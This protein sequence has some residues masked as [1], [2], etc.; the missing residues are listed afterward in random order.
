MAMVSGVVSGPSDRFGDAWCVAGAERA[1]R[2]PG[3]PWPGEPGL[4]LWDGNPELFEVS[5]AALGLEE[6]ALP[7]GSSL[8]QLVGVLAFAYGDYQVWPSQLHAVA[9]ELPRAV[10]ARADGERT[11]ASW[12]L[13]RLSSRELSAAELALRTDKAARYVVD[14]LGAPDV[15]AVQEIGSASDLDGLAAAVNDLAADVVYT[16]VLEPSS[17]DIEVGLLVRSSVAVAA[18]QSFG[19]AA[20]FELDGESWRTFDR[21]PLLLTGEVVDNGE[22]FP[23]SVLDVHLRSMNGIDEARDGPF[24]RAK[25]AAQARWLAA[26]LESRQQSQP[27]ERL[28]VVGDFNAFQF[29]DG[30]V[31]V[32]GTIVGAPDPA[33]AMVPAEDLVTRD[34]TVWTTRI[35]PEERYSF[36][37][38]GNA[39][40]FDHV[41][42]VAPMNDWVREVVYGRGNAD[43]P[44]VWQE[45]PASPLR[46]SDHDGVVLFLMTDRDGDG[47]GDDVDNCP[48]VVNPAQ[49]DADGD[50]VGDVCD[51]RTPRRGQRA[52]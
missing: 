39:Q 4:P 9:A 8:E 11:V 31:D 10:R 45:Q 22:P 46:S 27:E 24:V 23:L 19:E 16:S 30:W 37:F 41:L 29:T 44:V 48:D 38:E 2:E 42:T 25:R 21:P 51:G 33:G 32:L 40:A 12:N 6:T 17:S 20:Q 28:V 18:V 43:S 47:V 50:G 15:L 34:L 36:V 26:W 14:V 52:R 13:Q 1:W 7:A 35:E 49:R 5:V 3:L